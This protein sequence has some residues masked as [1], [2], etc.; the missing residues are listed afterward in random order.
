MKYSFKDITGQRFG[1]L[2]AKTFEPKLPDKPTLWICIC[3]CGK[4][5]KVRGSELRKG[6]VKSCG[7]KK[8]LAEGVA[9]LNSLYTRYKI[10]AEK[11]G[12]ILSL[13]LDEF[14][15]ITS[16]KCRYCG[17]DPEQSI[18]GKSNR[19]FNGDYLYNGIDRLDNKIGYVIGNCVAC[20]WVCNKMK[21]ILGE[22]EFVAQ[23]NLIARKY[24][25]IDQRCLEEKDTMTPNEMPD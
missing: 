19:L 23:V 8:K 22:K 9:A 11:R 24:P 4:E 18:S 13:S 7:C 25:V 10:S 21:G 6:N 16:S 2:I 1:K 17:K 14:K 15:V 20:C 3:D 5:M 12:F